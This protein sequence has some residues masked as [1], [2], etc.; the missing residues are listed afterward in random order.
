LRHQYHYSRICLCPWGESATLQ[1]HKGFV[2]EGG[3][4]LADH[5]KSVS[6]SGASRTVLDFVPLTSLLQEYYNC[7]TVP[8]FFMENKGAAHIERRFFQG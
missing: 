5:I 4:T 8:G 1:E 6:L 3:H 7:S 2:D